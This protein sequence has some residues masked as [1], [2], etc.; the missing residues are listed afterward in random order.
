[1]VF[2]LVYPFIINIT[3]IQKE[4]RGIIMGRII[5][6]I[7]NKYGRLT[8]LYKVESRKGQAYWHCRCDC[9][10][11]IDVSGISLRN[12]NTKS[13][14]CLQ[15]ERAKESNI[16]RAGGDLTGQQI[17]NLY[18]DSLF[19]VDNKRDGKN[20]RIWKCICK[21]GNIIYLSTANLNRRKNKSCDECAKQKRIENNFIDETGNKYGKLTVLSYVGKNSDNRF[22]WLCQCDC[23]NLKITTSKSLHSGLCQSCG[24]LKSKG[25]QKIQS[26]LQELKCNFKTQFSFANL[27]D[28]SKDSPLPLY[29]DFAIFDTENK[30]TGLIEYQGEQHYFDEY[31]KMHCA[32]WYNDLELQELHKRDLL[33]KEYCQLNNIPLV[34]IKYTDYNK[35]NLEYIRYVMQNECIRY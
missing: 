34:E 3:Y 18:I 27:R 5:N 21:C 31:K 12:G 6:E 26:L 32:P 28:Y 24:C 29:F 7:G 25:E 4:K 19:K 8:V 33:K 23:G 11:E 13:C 20:S 9:G 10:N 1:M 30:L 15:R 17:G 14:G 16:T 35:L 2:I 22:L